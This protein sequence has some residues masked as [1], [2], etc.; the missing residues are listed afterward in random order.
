MKNRILLV[1]MVLV[2]ILS[3]CKKD[4]PTP[5]VEDSALVNALKANERINEVKSYSIG[6]IIPSDWDAQVKGKLLGAY[7]E[8]VEFL[9]I[10][11]LDHNN[12]SGQS[13]YQRVRV[14]YAGDG[15]N[16]VLHT[17][18]YNLSPKMEAYYN[19]LAL[20]GGMNLVEV[21]HRYFYGSDPSSIDPNYN[22]FNAVQQSA[23][24]HDVV[25]DIKK[26][27]GGKWLATGCSKDGI[28]SALYAVHYPQDM[29]VYVPFD[30]PFC[31]GREDA[32]VGDFLNNKVGTKEQR[33]RIYNSQILAL[34][35]MD[36]IAALIYKNGEGKGSGNIPAGK[37][38]AY[39]DSV[40]GVVLCKFLDL[41]SYNPVGDWIDKV[42]QQNGGSVTVDSLYRYFYKSEVKKSPY[43]PDGNTQ[44]TYPYQVQA[45][46][47]LGSFVMD[48]SRFDAKYGLSIEKHTPY[49][50]GTLTDDDFKKVG[51][52]PFNYDTMKSV[53]DFVKNTSG[54]K[55]VFVYG[56]NDYWTACGIQQGEY[57]SQN[58][59]YHLITRGTHTDNLEDFEVKSE[60]DAVWADVQNFMK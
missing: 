54:V 52:R 3:S 14:F 31:I 12:Y 30:A 20:K 38:E 5:V 35:V 44:Y 11:P 28:T 26:I 13:F 55:M 34:D 37:M 51:T 17:A 23:D 60:A 10:Q 22:Y 32:R 21:E 59:K 6:E 45:W 18:G 24:L 7:K 58:V 19:A 41:W 46:L 8:C 43:T 15:K 53:T 39:R 25:T 29:S 1:M 40:R 48:I 2:A 4:E 50:K 16:T 56:G 49:L 9:Y 36:D 42:P 57:D 33:D 27:L 47:E